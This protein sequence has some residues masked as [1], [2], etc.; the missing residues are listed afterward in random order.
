MNHYP[1]LAEMEGHN[2]ELQR[3]APDRVEIRPLGTSA[4]GRPIDLVSIGEGPRS[5]LLVGTPHPNE[6]I[7]CA[8]ITSLMDRL[9]DDPAFEKGKGYRWHFIKSIDPDG[10]ALNEGWFKGALSYDDYLRDFFRPAFIRQPDYTFPFESDGYSFSASTPENLCWRAAFEVARPDLNVSLHNAEVGGVFFILTAGLAGVADKLASEVAVSGLQINEVGEA[11]YPTITPGVFL[12]DGIAEITT[13]LAGSGFVWEAG[14]SSAD[15]AFQRYGTET[16]ICEVPMWRDPRDSDLRPSG[17]T[18]AD[19]AESTSGERRACGELL[20]RAEPLLSNMA[21]TADEQA[22]YAA[23]ADHRMTGFSDVADA[24]RAELAVREIGA[25]EVIY[26]CA[27]VRAVS[28]VKRLAESVRAREASEAAQKLYRE[29]SDL[30]E[31]LLVAWPATSNFQPLPVSL[32]AAVQVRS[33]LT[34][35]KFCAQEV[36]LRHN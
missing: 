17:L 31:K 26:R 33:I 25:A 5:A 20:Q 21:T 28:M 29:T 6:P 7:G 30:L 11:L 18:L 16:L 23:V 2:R 34:A 12:N 32:A 24:Y 9:I 27:N 22:L 8:A 35:A 19:F 3:R 15:Y 10:V 36:N 1:T 13:R 14:S 4:Q